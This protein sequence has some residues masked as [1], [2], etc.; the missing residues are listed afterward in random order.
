MLAAPS[1]ALAGNPSDTGGAAGVQGTLSS[2]GGG[3]L[4]FTGLNIA[5]IAIAGVLLIGAGML[6]RRRG[7]S[8]R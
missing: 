4:P 7:A 2:G 8:E 6:M 1:A 5:V 3:N